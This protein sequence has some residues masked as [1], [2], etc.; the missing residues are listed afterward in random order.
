MYREINIKD[1]NYTDAY[2]N[3]GL[4]YMEIDSLDKAFE[5]MNLLAGVEPQNPFAYYHRGLIH[6]A[7]GN[8]EAAAIDLQNSINISPDFTLARE[9]LAEVKTKLPAQSEGE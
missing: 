8:Y 7:Y 3:A 5:Q 2:L 1:P 6:N 4:I 9:L